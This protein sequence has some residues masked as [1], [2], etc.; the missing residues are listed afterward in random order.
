MN[1][2][3]VRKTVR[4]SD[5]LSTQVDYWAKKEGISANEFI[6]ECIELGIRHMNKDYDIPT[7]EIERLVQLQE[8][9]VVLS[10]NIQSLEDVTVNSF[11]S[12][13]GLAQGGSYLLDEDEN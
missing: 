12:L 4:L 1:D 3:S 10:T 8:L 11:N 2:T 5:E 13:I 6:R 7:A 9:I